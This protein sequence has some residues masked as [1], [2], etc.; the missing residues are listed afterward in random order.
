VIRAEAHLGVETAIYGRA[1]PALGMLISPMPNL[2][3]GFAWRGRLRSDDWGWS[4]LQGI[5]A[6]GDLG[7]LHR[8]LHVYRPHELSWSAAY[9]PIPELEISAEVT[10]A[11]W[12][13]ARTPN[14][15]NAGGR[16][17]DTVI[18]A[19]GVRATPHPGVDLLGGY[20]YSQRV[21]DDLG[22][23]TNLLNN[24]AHSVG[25]G[26]A[27]DL[28]RLIEDEVPFTVSLG[29]RLMILED[30]EEVKNGRRFENDRQ[31]TTNPGYPGYRYGGLVPS[32]QLDIEAAW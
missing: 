29:G 14:W 8:F 5:E 17:G 13:Q 16:F 6:V 27:L 11:M 7:F 30:R 1:S 12:S 23:P 15:L 4:R 3:F 19:I 22:G 32:V 28:D 24:N 31:L 10:W 18:P 20:R 26:V 21:Y 9:A 2:R 25:L